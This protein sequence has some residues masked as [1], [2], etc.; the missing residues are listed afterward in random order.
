[1]KLSFRAILL[2]LFFMS[3]GCAKK[4]TDN[5][6]NIDQSTDRIADQMQDYQAMLNIYAIELEQLRAQLGVFKDSFLPLVAHM[7][8]IA[9]AA[10][11]ID[12]NVNLAMEQVVPLLEAFKEMVQQEKD[13]ERIEPKVDEDDL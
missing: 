4:T 11:G 8:T 7:Q 1:M 2:A 3:M 13:G 12:K 10:Q 6:D 5:V 9:L